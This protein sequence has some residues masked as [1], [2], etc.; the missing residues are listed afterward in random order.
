MEEQYFIVQINVF[1]NSCIDMLTL[2]SVLEVGVTAYRFLQY[3]IA[4][5]SR[6]RLGAH[7]IAPSYL[8]TPLEHLSAST[9]WENKTTHCVCVCRRIYLR[10]FE[11]I[12]DQFRPKIK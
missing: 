7:F 9:V 5:G 2:P 12:P 4:R 10:E 8:G 6:A 3:K 11:P 1:R